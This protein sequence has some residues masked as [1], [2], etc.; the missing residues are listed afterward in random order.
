VKMPENRRKIKRQSNNVSQKLDDNAR[1]QRNPLNIFKVVLVGT[2]VVL[3][4]LV[5]L[6]KI[7]N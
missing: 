5:L 7:A 3:L 4:A 6:A 2:V 1:Q